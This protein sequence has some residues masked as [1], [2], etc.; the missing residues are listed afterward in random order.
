MKQQENPAWILPFLLFLVVIYVVISFLEWF[1]HY[2]FM[3][4]NGSLST[5]LLSNGVD[6]YNSHMEHHKETK[7][8]QTLP[9]DCI[10][11]GLVFNMFDVEITLIV[12]SLFL[13]V[14]FVWCCVPFFNERFTLLFLL[15]VTFVISLVYFTSWSS[16]HSFYHQKYI[17][18]NVPLKNNNIIYSPV[19]FYV[20]DHTSSIY[21]YLFWYH[22]LHHL[23]KGE[24]KGNYNVIFPF[25]DFVLGTYTPKVDNTLHFSKNEPR[26]PSETW[27]QEHLVF[28]IRILDNNRIEYR[29]DV[30]SP[31]LPIP[32][33]EST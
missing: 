11:E 14:F 30:D 6:L 13:I 31:W 32:N 26:T 5:F 7:M 33:M 2:Y 28:D 1:L 19:P 22:T 12:C 24:S 18:T 15:G 4:M 17:P 21:Q 27:L 20:P 29:D 10:E 3:H 9:D 23:N 25:F 8:D 16:I